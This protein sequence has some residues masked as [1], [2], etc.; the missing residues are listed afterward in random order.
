[1]YGHIET[2]QRESAGSVCR[3]FYLAGLLSISVLAAPAGFAAS[4]PGEGV[5]VQPIQT[6]DASAEFQT[7]VVTIGLEVLGYEVQKAKYVDIPAAYIAISQGDGDYY[8][9]SWDPLQNAFY[10]RAGGEATL[11]RLGTLVAN[12]AQ[13]YLIDKMTADEHGIT[14]FE[15]LRDPNVAALFDS[16]DD[17]KA[18][19]IGCP[20]GWGC[21]RMIDY[22]IDA[23][24]LAE[25]VRHVQG[26]F[27]AT[28]TD[29]IGRHGAG[30]SVLYYSY[31][32]LWMNQILVPGEDVVWLAVEEAAIPEEQAMPGLQTTL[33]DGRDV[34]WPINNIRV[35]ANNEFLAANPSAKRW[36]DLV[37][38]PLADVNAQ[39]KRVYD[40]ENSNEAI[41]VHAEEW[42]AANQAEFDA[43]IEE[44]AKAN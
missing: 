36:F 38:I 40:G 41:R 15:Q 27:T 25:T 2:M 19:L 31:T 12:C 44:A 28:H 42:I 3:R 39:N 14:N 32:P 11:T 22:Q 9:Q 4:M 1:M 35:T 43:W 21:E 23:Y 20:P 10:E 33:P 18:D 13:G 5:T 37:S 6:E 7:A 34:G 8:A 17:G 29:A 26:D 16:D 30:E 24:G